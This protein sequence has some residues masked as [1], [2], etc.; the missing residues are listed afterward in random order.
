MHVE[1]LPAFPGAPVRRAAILILILLSAVPLEAEAHRLMV[2]LAGLGLEGGV[3]VAALES[4]LA[5]LAAMVL[6]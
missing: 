5:V 2:G 1:A 4:Y 6:L 3:G